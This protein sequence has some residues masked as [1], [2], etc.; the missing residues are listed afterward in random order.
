MATTGTVTINIVGDANKLKAALSES[1]TGLDKLS[2][3]TQDVGQKMVG[4]GAKM[5]LGVTAP[6]ALLGKKAFDAAS[7][8]NESLSKVG[9]VFGENSQAVLDWSKTAATAMGISR[10]EALE[11]AGTFGNLFSALGLSKDASLSMSEALVQLASDLASFN[12]ASPEDVLLAL[13]AGLVGE[14]EPLRKFGVSLSAARVESEALADGLVK[15]TGNF[16][17]IARAQVNLE[18][19]TIAAAKATKA[20]GA[21]SL[22]AR[23][24]STALLKAEEALT[25]ATAG[26][27]PDLNA[28]QKAQAAYNVIMKDTVMAQG[29]FARTA[30]GAANK[31]RILAAQFKDA[32]ATLGQSLIPI[33]QKLAAA[34]TTVFSAFSDLSPKTQEFIVYAGL[35]AAAIGPLTTLIGGL[36]TVLGVLISPVAL[37]VIAI[38]ALT[39]ATVLLYFHWDQVWSWMKDHP[40]IA[41]LIILL[42]GP[43]T[44]P[45]IAFVAL[46]RAM[47]GHW[48]Q[49]WDAMQTAATA[50]W[51]VIEPVLSAL[52]WAIR[53]IIVAAVRV[54]NAATDGFNAF[55]AAA[56]QM[57]NIVDGPFGFIINALERMANLAEK[58]KNL[59]G[60]INP[61]GSGG[62]GG[63]APGFLDDLTNPNRQKAG[64]GFIPGP[65]GRG[66]PILAHGGELVLNEQQQR[67]FGG[68]TTVNIV[69]NGFVG[70]DQDI[71]SRIA[72]VFSRAGGPTI[73]ARAIA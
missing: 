38:A 8:L 24:A 25:E 4:F 18:K 28:A 2:R 17:D 15:S 59:L 56:V 71:A 44:I 73:A 63:S 29:D 61:I 34:L 20:H 36:V 54:G 48:G 51:S 7:D 62:F 50:A 45:I 14:V 66:I 52:D 6:L 9:V 22:E 31:Q 30:D 64:G 23:D 21:E 12:N 49:V 67:G 43:V 1:E 11:S 16:E 5:T 13:R 41:A 65:R 46:M 69:V 10:Q 19:A 55:S 72:A 68:G 33:F 58:A 70:N 35:A 27:V 40:A 32:Q 3:T 37:V 60:A 47:Q 57:W 26:K 42:T 39:A 53:S